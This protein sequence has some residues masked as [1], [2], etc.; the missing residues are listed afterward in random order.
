MKNQGF[1]QSLPV[2]SSQQG[3]SIL[4]P[5][6]FAQAA[7]FGLNLVAVGL[8]LGLLCPTA[9]AQ[10]ALTPDNTLGAEGSQINSGSVRG[11]PA[12]LIEGG[13]TRGANLFHSFQDFN[14][15]AGQRVYFANPVGIESILGR[16]TGGN[17]TQ[18]FGT[19]GV[20]GPAN[21][22][23]LN[24]SGVLFGPQARLD[25]S[26]SFV[27]STASGFDFG[28]NGS[29]S[30]LN[31]TAPGQL[32]AVRIR[33][34]AQYGTDYRGPVS[35]AGSLAVGSGQ[36]LALAGQTVDV[37][38][39][40]QAPGGTVQVLGDRI[41]LQ[42][43]SRIEVSAPNGGGTVLVGGEFQ[44]RGPLP[45]AQTTT[46]AAG[47]AI[48]ADALDQG[49]GGRVIIWSDQT[50]RF[51]GTITAQGGPLG[52]NG[53][54]VEVSGKASLEFQGL[55]NTVAP[56]GVMGQLLLDPTNI[57]VVASGGN[58]N[59][60]QVNEFSD[61][62]VTTRNTNR[63][64]A[65]V[66]ESQVSDITL[67]ASGNIS[68]NAPVSLTTPG[69]DL[70]ATAG[71]SVFVN[72]GANITTEGGDIFLTGQT[73]EV[74]VR[75]ATLNAC[76]GG[77]CSLG[78]RQDTPAIFLSGKSGV[79]V[80]NS[81]L[82]NRSTTSLGSGVNR[83]GVGIISEAGSVVLDKVGISTTNFSDGDAGLIW[84]SALDKVEIR[85]SQGEDRLTLP[86]IFSRGG[87][88]GVLI[89]GWDLVPSVPTPREVIL[90]DVRI[91]VDNDTPVTT[92][93]NSG[94]L[95]ISALNSIQISGRS[96]ISSSTYDQGNAGTVTLETQNGSIGLSENSVIFSNVEPGGVGNG[97]EIKIITGD[98]TLK[99]NS[100][101]QSLVRGPGSQNPNGP[102]FAGGQGNGG[103]ISIDASGSVSL[104]GAS[105]IFSNVETGASGNA[106]GVVIR[107][108]NLDLIERSYIQ[109]STEAR[110]QGSRLN[111][112]Q[113]S[114]YDGTTSNAGIILLLIEDTLSLDD[115]NIFNNLEH[116]G[117]GN[118]GFIFARANS[119]YLRNGSQIQ[120]IVRGL[121][122]GRPPANG[123]AGNIFIL[124][125]SLVDI[126][127]QARG[128]SSGIF[129]SVE[130]GAT[131]NSGT[132]VIVSPKTF[133]RETGFI[134]VD[135]NSTTSGNQSGNIFI[136]S[137]RRDSA[138]WVHNRG[139]ITA[140]TLSGEG[141]N[142][143]LSIPGAVVLTGNGQITTE[144]QGNAAPGNQGGNI[145]IG[146]G[147][148][149]ESLSRFSFP[150]LLVGTAPA[151]NS[152]ISS[153]APRGRG[154]NINLL[155][156]SLFSIAN[157]PL[158]E[159]T[160]DIDASGAAD[161]GTVDVFGYSVDPSRGAVPN[162]DR[163]IDPRLSEGC[164]PRV[165]QSASRVSFTGSGGLPSSAID[166]VSQTPIPVGWIAS[167]PAASQGRSLSFA[168]ELKPSG[169]VP[170]DSL[171]RGRI[172]CASL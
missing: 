135:N 151:D 12:T 120:T 48:A 35:A 17:A 132:I 47:A 8:G 127:G 97:G 142:I 89:G 41:A 166:T 26:G 105:A 86:G 78:T 74:V 66:L 96:R 152:D 102:T 150:T 98:L 58:T 119:V 159:L 145:A 33:P 156:F 140:R 67:Q 111:R 115:S 114:T 22:F 141:G 46:V 94:G 52:G 83:S 13:A 109:T 84:I 125:G 91:N 10:S 76:R 143:W 146:T 108:A 137:D 92:A 53:G 87:G 131:G 170:I 20:N 123:D 163:P 149:E 70:F 106:G 101:I 160:N 45:N 51:G 171:A 112:D 90:D 155:S 28:A 116:G 154:G 38:G 56:K 44:G 29:F 19:L 4:T 75:D 99:D 55:V 15:A 63:I 14:V 136:G 85:N 121:Q 79:R 1:S 37:T 110:G 124:A 32:L 100:Q 107:A 139:V 165:Q 133:A 61:P 42:S 144:A 128:F 57:E 162:R 95:R 54:F 153:R 122:N 129:S 49:N 117:S 64:N 161:D 118:A 158:S 5:Y 39:T 18:I 68:F 71:N 23:L 167:Q 50:T 164:D 21:L 130:P 88:G 126:V 147:S 6:P 169:P 93:L 2:Q 62:N 34:G 81:D 31:P 72:P 77:N 60:E 172:I 9:I 103:I 24:P 25:M 134:K 30:A 104:S 27:A 148:L 16:V 113:A 82:L 73:G 11:L 3:R 157:R 80:S 43:G 138:V 40:L 59:P 36:T 168:P 65:S 69:Q 7:R